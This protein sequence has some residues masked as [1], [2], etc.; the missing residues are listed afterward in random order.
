MWRW[1]SREAKLWLYNPGRDLTLVISGEDPS[2][3][4][5]GGT[6]VV[7]LAGDKELERF[8]L[9]GHFSKAVKIP[10]EP[11][12]VSRGRITL[13][14][15]NTHVPGKRGTAPDLRELGIKIFDVTVY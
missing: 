14:V 15:A 2:R 9:S 7:V 13:R 6:E 11:L 1:T 12:S 5:R 3:H 10:A 8:T 4:Y